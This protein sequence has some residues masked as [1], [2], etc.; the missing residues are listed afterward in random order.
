MATNKSELLKKVLGDIKTKVAEDIIVDFKEKDISK[1][2][3]LCS[4]GSILVDQIAPL[5]KA[6]IYEVFGRESSGKSSLAI[7]ACA[8]VIKKGGIAAYIDVECA[9]NVGFAD[10]LG[11]QLDNPNFV[12][13]QPDTQEDAMAA[14]IRL[15]KSGAVD[16]VVLDS[17][18]ALLP[19]AY[20]MDDKDDS[21]ELSEQRIGVRAK[22]LNQSVT[23]MVPA[24]K[25]TGTTC[26]FI[27]QVRDNISMFGGGKPVVGSGH[28]LEFFSSC[29]IQVNSIGKIEGDLEDGS[30]GVISIPIK[31]KTVKNKIIAPFKEREIQINVEGSN[32]GIDLNAE[33]SQAAMGYGILR[34][35]NRG[36]L[37]SEETPL[38]PN[39]TPLAS[40]L[41]K[42][43]EL[44]GEIQN[45]E[46]HPLYWV[47]QEIILRVKERAKQITEDEVEKELSPIYLQKEQENKYAE[48]YLQL[49]S[50]A[51]SS[52]KILEANYYINKAFGYNQFDKNIISKYKAITKRY[53][54]KKN[55]FQD[56]VIEV[57][58]VENNS[59][60]K[61]DL[62]SGEIFNNN[63]IENTEQ[64]KKKD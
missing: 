43:N 57:K 13:I 21:D 6:K 19:K 38:Y 9:F 3:I 56:F 11:L 18:N 23:Q 41:Q 45:N 39:D 34:K 35:D 63:E 53:E 52:S 7:A 42:L 33:Y 8:N 10:A 2:D 49:A 27:S 40:S 24:C 5:V 51:S 44:L 50:S 12:L 59:T 31:V 15:V 4:W 28:S 14:M 47:Q 55:S 48:E 32:K 46:K 54:E 61:I 17:T 22:I 58:D 37:F 62:E 64:E 36:I 30:R 20:V 26:I 60:I 25:N 16:L 1:L 29:R